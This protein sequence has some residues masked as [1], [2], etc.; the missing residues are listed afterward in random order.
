ME[1]Y[2]L[3]TDAGIIG[4][5][6]VVLIEGK[7]GSSSSPPTSGADHYRACAFATAGARS[8]PGRI[9][10]TPGFMPGIETQKLS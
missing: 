9:S 3:V 10:A 7:G 8:C 1:G 6:A 2:S 4:F 5:G